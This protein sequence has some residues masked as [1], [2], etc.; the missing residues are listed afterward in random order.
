MTERSGPELLTSTL[1]EFPERK[2]RKLSQ[3][4]D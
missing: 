4:R 3:C 2:S 1:E